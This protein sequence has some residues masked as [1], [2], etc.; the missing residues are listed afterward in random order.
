MAT[1]AYP[2]AWKIASPI[3]NAGG[4]RFPANEC[5]RYPVPSYFLRSESP[6]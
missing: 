2:I 4:D 5:R 1:I 3:P 6:P